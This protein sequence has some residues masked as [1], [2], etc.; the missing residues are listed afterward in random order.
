MLCLRN[1]CKTCMK[2][3]RLRERHDYYYGTLNR[4]VENYD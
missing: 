3:C 4:K 2:V 1:A